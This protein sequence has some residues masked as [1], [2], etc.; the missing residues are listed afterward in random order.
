V[1]PEHQAFC[2]DAWDKNKV[3][4]D[5]PYTPLGSEGTTL[6]FPSTIGGPNWG[7][8]SYNPAMGYLIVNLMNLGA[9]GKLVKQP[10]GAPYSHTVRNPIDP[11]RNNGPQARMTRFWD[12][13]T[14]MPCNEPPWGELVTINVNTGDIVWKTTLGITEA[15]GEKG[16]HTGAPNLGGSIVTASGL[17]FI[18]ATNDR[19][20]RAFDARSGKE[21]WIAEL[22]AS[23]NAIPITYQGVDGRQYVVI[24]A[25][26][27]GHIG[28]NRPVSDS[29]VAFALPR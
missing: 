11:S 17:V 24:A 7:G 5:G 23:G 28:G 16:L 20:F 10:E 2:A 22:D 12:P 1:T 13:A 19:R 25:G 18:G 26:G 15:L 4:N 8:A 29:L 9:L 14:L 27:G 21:L 6:W 3:Y